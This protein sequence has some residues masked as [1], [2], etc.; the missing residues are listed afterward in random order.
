[1]AVYPYVPVLRTHFYRAYYF[2]NPRASKLKPELVENSS[3]TDEEE[4]GD[5][6]LRRRA[7]KGG[8]EL[9]RP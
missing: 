2:A 4:G 6:S 8:R 5:L 3:R 1:M 7:G 9:E